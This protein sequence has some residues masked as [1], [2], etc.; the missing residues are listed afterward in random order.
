MSDLRA[1]LFR[2][3]R[4]R[5]DPPVWP[6]KRTYYADY[7]SWWRDPEILRGLGPGLAAL[8]PDC[9]ATVVMGTESRGSLIGPLVATHLGIGFA[10]VRKGVTAGL[11]R[12][13]VGDQTHAAGLQRPPPE[14]GPPPGP[15]PA[16]GTVSCS[17]TTGPPQAHKQPRACNSPRTPEPPG[18]APQLSSM[19]L[20]TQRTDGC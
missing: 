1:A 19:H 18:L 4:W 11:G 8:F 9:S 20:R 6:E 7:T 10:E 2:S 13:S 5:S 12:R 17:S 15:D 16:I 14:P 3:F